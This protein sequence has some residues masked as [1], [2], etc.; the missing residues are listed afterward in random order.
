[1]QYVVCVQLVSSA[2]HH[3][4]AL[5]FISHGAGEHCQRYGHVAAALNEIG[6]FVYAHD[7][8]RFHSLKSVEPKLSI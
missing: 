2:S 7:H 8:G 3:H 1:M 4:R 5:V 6:A